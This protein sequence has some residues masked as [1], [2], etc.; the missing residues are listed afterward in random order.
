MKNTEILRIRPTLCGLALALAALALS[1]QIA[2]AH[3][4]ASGITNTGGNIYFILNESADSVGV[5]FPDNNSTNWLGA[6]LAAGVQ[7]FPIGAGTNHYQIWVTKA[8]AGHLVQLSSD[9]GGINPTLAAQSPR[10]V[11]VNNNPNDHNFGRIYIADAFTGNRGL[12][13]RNAD[14]SDAMGYGTTAK[15]GSI[16]FV[17]SGYSP[18]RLYVGVDDT[19][20]IGNTSTLASGGFLA[21]INPDLTAGGLVLAGAYNSYSAGQTHSDIMGTPVATGSTNTGNLVISAIDVYYTTNDTTYHE[22]LAIETWNIGSGPFPSS[23]SPNLPMGPGP[24]SGAFIVSDSWATPNNLYWMLYRTSYTPSGAPYGLYVYTNNPVGLA[25][26]SFD[27]SITHGVDL[28]AQ[29]VGVAVSPDG[30]LL[31]TVLEN[32]STLFCYLTNGIPNEATLFTNGPASNLSSTQHGSTCFDSAYN[33]YNTSS[34]SS[35]LRVY[36]LGLN[37]TCI[38]ANDATTT[39]GTFQIIIPGSSVGVTASPTMISQSHAPTSGTFTITR[40]GS[41]ANLSQKLVVNFTL[42][43]TATNGTYTVSPAGIM[44]VTG[45][46][47]TVTFGPSVT[48]TNIT[49]TAVNDNLPRPTTSVALTLGSGNYNPILPGIA[50]ILIQNTGPQLVFVSGVAVPTMYRAYSNDYASFT[51]TRWGDTNASAYPVSSFTTSGNGG[52]AVAGTDYTAPPTVTVHPGD[53]TETVSISPLNNGQLP[54]HTSSLYTYVGNKTA[55]IGLSSA[56]GYTAAPGTA[57]MTILDCAYPPAG[58]VLFSD[59]LTSTAV[60]S[61]PGSSG[62]DYV[63]TDGVTAWYATEVDSADN[64][65]ADVTINFGYDF[66]NDP[67]GYDSGDNYIPA[68]PSGATTALRLT[69]NKVHNTSD[70]IAVNLY[71]TNFTFSG[72]YAVRFQMYVVQGSA[73]TPAPAE[74]G[75][76]P[77]FGINHS[78][79]LTNWWSDLTTTGG[80]WSMDGVFYWFTAWAGHYGSPIYD[81]CEFTGVTNCICPANTGAQFPEAWTYAS[82]VNSFKSNVFTSLN[83]SSNLV[84]GVPANA[85]PLVVQNYSGNWADVQIVNSNNVV[86]MDINKTVVF[87]YVNTNSLFQQGTLMLGYEEPNG[88]T[89]GAEAA[90]YFSN[91]Q[92]VSLANPVLTITSISINGAGSVVIT[93]TDSSTS[94]TTA[95]FALQHA[96]VLTGLPGEFSDVSPVAT[97]SGGS[98]SFQ[99]TYPQN[100]NAQFYRVRHL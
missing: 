55:I 13:V 10:G 92:V 88:E 17:A 94:D 38:T 46:N 20:Y 22:P 52:T 67:S 2:Q 18:Y 43:G 71:P 60:G 53:L 68:A 49:I 84:G 27:N 31:A 87:S 80:P 69:C 39:N 89:A 63:F 82:F 1:S 98:G 21:Y 28:F 78:G 50:T 12:F 75:E 41:P 72:N 16:P 7:H 91:L 85:S 64:T 33:L 15:A 51:I 79:T 8:G 29:S 65:P 93:F 5:Y 81:M 99:V 34:Y 56:G 44:D 23:V 48:T 4:Y 73:L 66:V 62:E 37:T 32:G 95:S 9:T 40:T 36:S 6:N 14:L 86:T 3:P 61:D 19:V 83:T 74:T 11:A 47:G 45:T 25:W 59:A 77:L 97:F 100:G 76:G 54:V 42:G 70:G 26:D 57:T 90:V 96:A 35:L 58:S 30:Q 24:Y